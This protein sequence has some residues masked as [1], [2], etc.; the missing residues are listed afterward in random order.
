[1]PIAI[2][3]LTHSFVKTSVFSFTVLLYD[4]VAN[5][6]F[7]RIAFKSGI[8]K[9]SKTMS[10]SALTNHFSRIAFKSELARNIE[11]KKFVPD[12]YFHH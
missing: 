12:Q 2:P 1:M 8:A 7:P 4:S 3:D 9:E 10:N 6:V 5:F 11:Y